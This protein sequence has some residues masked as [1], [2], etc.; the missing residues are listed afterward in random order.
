MTVTLDPENIHRFGH[1]HCFVADS[2]TEN[3]H[4][5]T[6]LK[7]HL[8]IEDILR[9]YLNPKEG[10]CTAVLNVDEATAEEV[11][12]IRWNVNDRE[13]AD[14]NGKEC[15]VH[16]LEEE[17]SYEIRFMAYIDGRVEQA[18]TGIMLYDEDTAPEAIETEESR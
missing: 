12:Q 9:R 1:A 15:V 11:A 18:A 7:R 6:E 17:Q 4:A 5:L 8:E 10:E 13:V 16:N 2:D 14:Y 3:G